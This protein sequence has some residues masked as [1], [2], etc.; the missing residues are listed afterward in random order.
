MNNVEAVRATLYEALKETTTATS[1]RRRRRRRPRQRL[2]HYQGFRRRVGELVH[3]RYAD[4]RSLDRRVSRSGWRWRGCA[5]SPR[6]SSPIS[7][8]H[9]STRSSARRQKHAIAPTASIRARSSFARPMAAACAARFRTRSRWRRS[10]TTCRASRSSR[11]RSRLDVKGLLKYRD[12]RSGSGAL[13]GAQ[14]NLSPQSRARF[15]TG[16]ITI[17]FGKANVLKERA[18]RLTVVSYGL[19][20]A[21]GAGG[22]RRSLQRATDSPFE[23]IDLR[24]I[25]PM[26]KTTILSSVEKT[27][28]LLIIHEDNKF[29]GIG[30]EISAMV[31]EDTF[32]HLDAPIRLGLRP[33]RP[34]DGL[35]AAARG[36]VYAPPPAEM[37]R[38][39]AR[40]VKV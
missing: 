11:R 36:R 23:V 29:G 28:K 24:S 39:D 21:L 37:A 25:R 38:R 33:R 9:R 2:P 35:C 13:P 1:Y 19:L 4:R 22:S 7:S 14:E 12:R 32:F 30:A 18:P 6:F 15:R 20:R 34:G 26:D 10:S 16:T 17:P 27:R 31:A 40:E 5:L 3:H 8:T